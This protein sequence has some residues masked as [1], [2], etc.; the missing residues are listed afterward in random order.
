MSTDPIEP[1]TQP[2]DVDTE[3]AFLGLCL[4][5]PQTLTRAVELITGSEFYRGQH[6][7]LWHLLIRER[8]AARATDIVSINVAAQQVP[9]LRRVITADPTWLH[10]IWHVGNQVAPASLGSLAETLIDKA[11]RRA[12]IAAASEAIQNAYEYETAETVIEHATDA[13]TMLRYARQDPDDLDSLRTLD[14]FCEQELPPEDFICGDL[15]ARGERLVITGT[16]GTGKALALDTPI[17]TPKGWTTMG[18]L[19]V[20]S[21]VF[22]ADGTPTRVTF[23]T[24]V[25]HDRPCYRVTFSDGSSIV[26]DAEHRW[27]TETLAA[28]EADAKFRKKP[29]TIKPRGTDQKH[30]R[31]HF[32]AV[33]TT[34]QIADTLHARNGHALNH[35]IQ[36]C[37]PLQ[38]PAQELPIDPYVLGVWLGDGTSAGAG[39]TCDDQ[40]IIDQVRAAGET[41][42]RMSNCGPYAWTMSTGSAD[43]RRPSAFT[44]RLKALGVRGNKHIP[45]TYLHASV[46]QRLALIQGLMDT[47]GTACAEGAASGR[48]NGAALLEFSV[49]SERLARGTYELLLGLGIKVKLQTGA[50]RIYG[51][52]CGLRYR[53]SFQTDLPMFRLT[54][55][56]ERQTPSRTRRASLHY[57]TAVEPVESVPVR[58]IQVEH[59]SHLFVA[60]ETC[61]PTHNTTSIRQFA[62]CTAAGLHPFSLRP[63]EPR[64]VLA[65]DLENPK[66]I[67]IHGWDYLRRAARQQGRGVVDGR[68]MIDRAPAGLDLSK[69]ADQRWIMRRVEVVKPDLLVIGPAYKMYVGGGGDREETLAR[70]VTAFLDKI[71]E[72]TDCALILEHHSPHK[73]AGAKSRD[74]RP[75]GSSLWLR[76]PEFGWGIRYADDPDAAKRRLVDIVPWRGGRA[77]RPWPERMERGPAGWAWAE[78][79]PAEGTWR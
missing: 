4:G 49:T 33:V 68:L 29:Q 26:A 39:L 78:A 7:S 2:Q 58:C 56:V 32:P 71:R 1:R 43:N 3:R 60:G 70:L 25:M 6:E 77:E 13:F 62:V 16:E 74:V 11:R 73:V 22:A 31:V 28:R 5:S 37:Q 20:G 46:D 15:L 19:A 42:R 75:I 63:C 72:L 38:Y 10:T 76:W 55:K 34:Q 23:A 45:E 36:T 27:L 57:V 44:M 54:R 65:L 69:V 21:E 9:D 14:E 35:S 59:P 52:D 17:P 24:G 64:R 30:K 67:M 61:I 8:D 40:E 66:R 79:P 12:V 50:A 48:G 41:C 53:L 47:D 51:K 18:E